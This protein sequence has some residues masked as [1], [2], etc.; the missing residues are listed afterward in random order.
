M[1]LCW[2]ASIAVLMDGL[3]ECQGLRTFLEGPL[4]GTLVAY[5]D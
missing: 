5:G 3:L 4:I 2:E 1:G